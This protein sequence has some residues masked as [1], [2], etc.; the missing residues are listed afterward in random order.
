MHYKRQRHIT[1]SMFRIVSK[2][3]NV[4]DTETKLMR[5]SVKKIIK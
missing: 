2:S 4:F 5:R 3:A 1:I